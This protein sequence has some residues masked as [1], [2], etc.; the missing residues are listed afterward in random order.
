MGRPGGAPYGYSSDCAPYGSSYDDCWG[1][2]SG[3]IVLSGVLLSPIGSPSDTREPMESSSDLLFDTTGNRGVG[4][5]RSPV[6][7]GIKSGIC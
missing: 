3:G 1:Y 4:V 6:L 5:A 7:I 2:G